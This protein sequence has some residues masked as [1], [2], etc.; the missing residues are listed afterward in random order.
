[1]NVYFI[2]GRKIYTRKSFKRN[3]DFDKIFWSNVPLQEKLSSAWQIIIDA[4]LIKGTPEKL[5]FR[6]VI[7]IKTLDGKII[8]KINFEKDSFK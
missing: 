7:T 1:M 6:K 8:R 4:M 2:K 3:S 5:K